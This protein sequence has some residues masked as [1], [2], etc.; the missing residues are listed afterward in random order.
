MGQTIRTL[1]YIRPES[2][3]LQLFNRFDNY[4]APYNTNELLIP[5]LA[6]DASIRKGR[7]LQLHII[8]KCRPELLD[9]HLFS[10]IADRQI[11]DKLEIDTKKV[12]KKSFRIPIK[13]LA[14]RYYIFKMPFSKKYVGQDFKIYSG[15]LDEM[16]QN[17]K[18]RWFGFTIFNLRYCLR[19]R[20]SYR[21]KSYQEMLN[22][23][24]KV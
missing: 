9:Y 21:I 10:G 24:S 23:E 14:Y 19:L 1:L 7:K 6:M 11:S 15:I 3:H 17:Y 5:M 8:H 4:I 18:S 12:V 13:Y 20:F 22:C 16:N 2:E